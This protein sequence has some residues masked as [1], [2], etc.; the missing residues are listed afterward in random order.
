LVSGTIEFRDPT[1]NNLINSYP[2]AD[3]ADAQTNAN[4]NPLTLNAAGAAASGL[5]LEDGVKYKIILK[6]SAGATVTTQDDVR[7]PLYSQASIGLLFNPQTSAESS[8]GITPTNY[9]REPGDVRRYGAV[10]DGSTDDYQAFADA[11]SSNRHI[12]AP[13]TGSGYKIGTTL[14]ISTGQKII[15]VYDNIT[16]TGSA[17]TALFNI[18]SSESNI[19][20]HRTVTGNANN[21]CVEFGTGTSNL[22]EFNVTTNF[23]VHFAFIQRVGGKAGGDTLVENRIAF[24]TMKGN[25][26]SGAIGVL[27]R[28]TTGDAEVAM[29]GTELIGGFIFE[30]NGYGIKVEQNVNNKYL[31][32]EGVMDFSTFDYWVDSSANV[33]N[34]VINSKFLDE[35]DSQIGKNDIIIN[36]RIAQVK[37]NN[38]TLASSALDLTC[39]TGSPLTIPSGKL[40][41]AIKG[42]TTEATDYYSIIAGTNEALTNAEDVFIAAHYDPGTTTPPAAA[43]AKTA[44]VSAVFRRNDDASA[45]VGGGFEVRKRA[46]S[47]TADFVVQLANGTVL[48]D[49]FLIRGNGGIGVSNSA[50]NTNTPSGATAHQL[51]IYDEA[52]SLLGYIP[53]YGSAW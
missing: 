49:K 38:Q 33:T 17:N 11:I 1:T 10:G 13:D 7:C 42:G 47:D 29:E 39:V 40:I 31:Y 30:M 23:L 46:S 41:S 52:G 14:S 32:F 28:N 16:Y 25:S 19:R 44:G 3:D 8:A 43:D 21:Y 34:A 48:G 51:P 20:C 18:L 36:G 15:D 5:Y 26:V 4:S 45:N 22:L 50:T 12:V 2:T 9:F 24:K 27:F 35:N 37:I 53:V 6:D